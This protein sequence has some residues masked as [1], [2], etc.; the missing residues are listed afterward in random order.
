MII[1]PQVFDSHHVTKQMSNQE[2]GSV[3]VT[4][5]HHHISHQDTE[6]KCIGVKSESNHAIDQSDH[7]MEWFMASL[8][9]EP[10]DVSTQPH[11]QSTD[12]YL[13]CVKC[14]PEHVSTQSHCQ[15]SESYL[16]C[17]NCESQDVSTQSHCQ[18]GESQLACVK[19]EPQEV[20]TKPHWGFSSIQLNSTT[21]D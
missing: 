3:T 20:S 13:A 12:S 6:C 8:K 19:C 4:T 10:Q 21:S 2:E 16:A 9:D 14:E 7:Q 5:Q 1:T 17:V 11:C 18:S 15:S